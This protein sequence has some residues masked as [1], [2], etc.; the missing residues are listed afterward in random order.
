MRPSSSKAE[1][2]LE[3]ASLAQPLASTESLSLAGDTTRP[4]E[5]LDEGDISLIRWMLA[6]TPTERLEMAQDFLE[7]AL[8]LRNGRRVAS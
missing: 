8:A 2:N 7:G 4:E 5:G 6:M 3:N 1:T